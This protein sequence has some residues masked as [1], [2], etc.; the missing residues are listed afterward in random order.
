MIRHSLRRDGLRRDGLRRDG[1]RRNSLRSKGLPSTSLHRALDQLFP[2]LVFV[3]TFCGSTVYAGDTLQKGYIEE[4]VVTAQ[5]RVTR[6]QETPVTITALS[7]AQLEASGIHDLQGLATAVPGLV[8]SEAV[9]NAQ[10]SIRGIGTDIPNIA[11]E[12]G[13]AL[14]LDGVYIKSLMQST[15]AF[16]DLER[17]EVLRGPQGTLYGRNAMGGAINLI[18]RRAS[19]ELEVD[20]EMTLANYDQVTGRVGISGPVSEGMRFRVALEAN[21]RDGYVQNLANGK[22]LD[23]M[24][25]KSFRGSWEIDSS[26]NLG[27]ILR[28]DYQDENFS[29]IPQQPLAGGP[30]DSFTGLDARIRKSTQVLANGA[31]V[32]LQPRRVFHDFDDAFERK[33]YGTSIEATYNLDDYTLKSITAFR[34]DDSSA[35]IDSDGTDVVG[36]HLIN[37]GITEQ[38]TQEIQ[39]ISEF[40][41]PMNFIVGAYYLDVDDFLTIDA[42]FGLNFISETDQDTTSVALFGQVDYKVTDALNLTLGARWNRDRKG[43]DS[44][45]NFNPAGMSDSRN[46]TKFTPKL[47]LDYQ[48]TAT[49]FGYANVSKGFKAGGFD[50]FGSGLPFRQEEVLAYEVGLKN[51]FLNNS[52]LL[53]LAFF[54]NDYKDL[55]VTQFP[56]D[57]T[58]R[59]TNAASATLRGIDVEFNYKLTGSVAVHGG[60]SYLDAQYDE[61]L[62]ADVLDPAGK[63]V[64]LKGNQLIRAPELSANL[65]LEVSPEFSNHFTSRLRIE[66]A[67]VDDYYFSAFN[68]KP[69]KQAAYSM[70]NANA[71]FST[72]DEK[73]QVSMFGKT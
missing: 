22:D 66:A 16:V 67:Y 52:L 33:I 70:V 44:M 54:Y 10:M 60:I 25:R 27:L 7:D 36:L 26:P 73:W 42:D 56:G 62:T 13:V 31:Q 6:L 19:D 34:K 68:R 71:T 1:L 55:Q 15:A 29:G 9:S 61:F 63:L 21:N 53:N 30:T 40:D 51:N 32:I 45:S 17:I 37:T 58:Q 4:V 18:T 28:A 14:H 11:G 5:K 41:S 2:G 49:S 24:Q 48:F 59:I 72:L 12:P 3:L 20:T 69:G 43:F 39:L 50:I 8:H 23:D 38:F 65:A 35:L 57:G 64:D 47:G 46:F